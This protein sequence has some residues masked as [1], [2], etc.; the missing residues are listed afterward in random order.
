MITPGD[1]I[2]FDDSE[3]DDAADQQSQRDI[4]SNGLDE[5]DEPTYEDGDG[6]ADRLEQASRASDSSYLLDDEESDED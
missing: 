3:D 5:E 2:P 6:D 4:H 1:E